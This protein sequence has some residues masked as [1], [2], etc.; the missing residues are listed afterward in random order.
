M[1]IYKEILQQRQSGYSAVQLKI[2]K[3][4]E[5]QLQSV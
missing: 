4:I 1:K 3:I 2:Y 5:Q